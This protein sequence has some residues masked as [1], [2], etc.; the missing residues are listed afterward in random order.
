WRIVIVIFAPAASP[1][2]DIVAVVVVGRCTARASID[3]TANRSQGLG[4]GLRR[5]RGLERAVLRELRG[6]RARS[7][8]VALR[9]EL[10]PLP[11]VLLVE[12]ACLR[13]RPRPSLLGAC[14]EL[15]FIR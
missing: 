7:E 6:I 8:Q 9:V 14:R 15:R 12:L 2:T 5:L 3:A 10:I 4:I 11:E 13:F 1:A